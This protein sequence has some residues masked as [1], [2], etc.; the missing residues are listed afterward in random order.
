M[1]T[2][3]K[4]GKSRSKT[5]A[6]EGANAHHGSKVVHVAGETFA[7]HTPS[8]TRTQAKSA[9]RLSQAALAQ[10]VLKREGARREILEGAKGLPLSPHGK[11]MLAHR[12]PDLMSDLFHN[13]ENQVQAGGRLKDALAGFGPEDRAMLARHF[14]QARVANDIGLMGTWKHKGTLKRGPV[15][16]AD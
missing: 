7:I 12:L 15:T 8:G 9:V 3:E 5:S 10:G 11:A 2:H 6:N 1:D 14:E 4:A 13:A 16:L